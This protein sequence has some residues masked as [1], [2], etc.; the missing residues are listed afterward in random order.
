M[1]L[2][3]EPTD[4]REKRTALLQAEIALREQIEEVARLRRDLP[5]GR[6]V[7]NYTFEGE[8]GP[9]TLNDLFGDHSTLLMYSYMFGPD[10]AQPC[11]MCSAFADSLNG[12]MKHI[13]QRLSLVMVARSSIDRLLENA[14]ARGWT[15]LSWVSAAANNYPVDFNSELPDGAQ[16]PM[17]NVFVK[18]SGNIHHYWTSE[19][20][21]E[22][23]PYHPR[24]V[25]M[26]WPLWN[27]FDLTPEGR[28]DFMPSL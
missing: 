26:I 16:I 17:I 4:Y 14:Q 15:D 3:D 19:M 23:S 1:N 6:Q 13:S 5:P 9:V 7:D 28:G 21:F 24:H 11:P 10:A 8:H 18:R 27:I 12:Q 2:P 25:D 22:P 20:F